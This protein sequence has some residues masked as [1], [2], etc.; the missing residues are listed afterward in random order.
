MQNKTRNPKLAKLVAMNKQ[1]H[2]F[3][4]SAASPVKYI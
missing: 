3:D 1:Y 4:S 2:K